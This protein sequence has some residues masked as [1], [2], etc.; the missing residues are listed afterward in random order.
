MN[1]IRHSMLASSL[2]L[3]TGFI[4]ACSPS[5]DSG[6]LKVLNDGSCYLEVQKRLPDK[7]ILQGWAVG[8]PNNSPSRIVLEISEG[9]N[10]QQHETSFFDRPDIA[11]AYKNTALTKTGFTLKLPPDKAPTG[12]KVRI[13]AEQSETA[14]AC[15]STFTL[16]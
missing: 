4:A 15:K 7:V 13:I 6:N 12:A 1:L 2:V 5:P 10:T 16:K 3:S 14:H 8:D 11:K 9:A